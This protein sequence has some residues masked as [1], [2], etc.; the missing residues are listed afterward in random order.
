M[1][2]L[3][4]SR[5]LVVLVLALAVLTAACGDDATEP[6][7][8]PT[9]EPIEDTALPRGVADE[10]EPAAEADVEVSVSWPGT[11]PRVTT[12]DTHLDLDLSEAIDAD[13]IVLASRYSEAINAPTPGLGTVT[14][15]EDFV[16]RFQPVPPP[17]DLDSPDAPWW[18]EDRIRACVPVE[19]G[20][21]RC[22]NIDIDVVRDDVAQI[23]A[24][25]AV[26][27]LPAMLSPLSRGDSDDAEVTPG[28]VARLQ[29]AFAAEWALNLLAT[30]IDLPELPA[31]L[32]TACEASGNA[33]EAL[34]ERGEQILDEWSGLVDVSSIELGAAQGHEPADDL[35]E[36]ANAVLGAIG[37]WLDCRT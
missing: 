7:T 30:T 6:E 14:P 25:L 12:G 29:D 35:S 20:R 26:D 31:H 3:E 24:R 37:E 1:R 34:I 21:L 23:A 28:G 36:Q 11:R 13:C 8:M 27:T 2:D 4:P 18:G 5:G 33:P 16:V 10:C 22:T 32:A 17:S 19:G 15:T 9:T